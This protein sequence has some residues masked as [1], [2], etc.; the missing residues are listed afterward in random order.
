[1][2]KSEHYI[3]VS[4]KSQEFNQFVI[5]LPTTLHLE[6]SWKCALVE[7]SIK[8]FSKDLSNIP[9]E[10]YI[11][12]NFCSTSF[13]NN[14]QLPILRKITLAKKTFFSFTPST[15]FYI[16]IKQDWMNRLEFSMGDERLGKVEIDENTEIRFTLHLKKY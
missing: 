5:E 11:L 2:S 6:G 1:M 9:K 8:F 10:I 14:L 4:S 7:C 13:F 3:Y 12:S 15:R 16:P